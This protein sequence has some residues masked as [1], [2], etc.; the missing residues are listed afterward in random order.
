[1]IAQRHHGAHVDLV[2]GRQHGGGVLRV[3]ERR[4]MVCRSLVCA[5]AL[6]GAASSAGEGA[7]T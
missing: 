3:L 1:M 7:R 2:E 6:H 5:S 4:A